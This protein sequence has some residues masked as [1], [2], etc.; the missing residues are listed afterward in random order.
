MRPKP[1]RLGTYRRTVS[2][3]AVVALA[4][5]CSGGDEVTSELRSTAE[6]PFEVVEHDG[7]EH[8]VGHGI[9]LRMPEGW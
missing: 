5:G 4:G 3:L 2:L 6:Q 8:V 1:S 9:T 7:G